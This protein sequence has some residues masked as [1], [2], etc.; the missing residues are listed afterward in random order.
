MASIVI[1]DY[2]MGNLRSV[3]KAFERINIPAIITSDRN[4]IL[5]AGKLILPGVGHFKNGMARLHDLGLI[6]IL[7]RKVLEEKIPILGICLGMQL[8]TRH[9]EEGDC[10]GLGY[11]DAVTV[12]FKLWDN[13]IKIPHMGWNNVV[14]NKGSIYNEELFPEESYYF[15]HS[16]HVNCLDKNDI[17]GVTNYGYN[18]TSAIRKGNVTGFQFHP[19]KSFNSGLRLLKKFCS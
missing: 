12:K 6:D 2:G 16:Y 4:V 8:F 11:F 13:C 10:A 5:S 17:I 18:F 9:S 3:Q 19:E 1:I 14:F 7:N 15:V